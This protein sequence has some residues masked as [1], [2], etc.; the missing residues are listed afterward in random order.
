MSPFW[1]KI[2]ILW[3][4]N[5][6]YFILSLN[7]KGYKNAVCTNLFSLPNWSIYNKR[8]R[9]VPFTRNLRP[10]QGRRLLCN[11]GS[12]MYIWY[13]FREY[14]TTGQSLELFKV[15][16]K[17]NSKW[18]HKLTLWAPF[19]NLKIITNLPCIFWVHIP[20]TVFSVS[21]ISFLLPFP[22]P[23]GKGFSPAARGRGGEGAT[24][25]GARRGATRASGWGQI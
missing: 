3:N 10:R 11:I 19:H 14:S 6:N 4:R 8:L 16:I 13:F 21:I 15:I 2:T 24:R 18:A 23:S 25:G 7:Q 9:H 17:G 5:I 12:V 22:N 1:Q 20:L